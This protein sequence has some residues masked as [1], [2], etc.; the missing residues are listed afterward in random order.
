MYFRN[1]LLHILIAIVFLCFILIIGGCEYHTDK[2]YFQDVSI[3][4]SAGINIVLDPADTV[5][6]LSED[7]GFIYHANS[8]NRKVYNVR[9]FVDTVKVADINDSIGFFKL[10]VDDYIEG[11]HTLTIIA[12]TST[13]SGSLADLLGSEGFVFSHSWDLIV[14]KLAPNA[15][16][17]TNIFN[18]NGVLRIE[19]GIFHK[20]HFQ[21]YDVTKSE[22]DANGYQHVTTIASINQQNI[23]YCYDRSFAGGTASYEVRVVAPYSNSGTSDPR[24]F[25][26]NYI[27]HTQWIA[28]DLVKLDWEKCRYPG[29]FKEYRIYQDN[30]L[31]YSSNNIDSISF[32][33][34][35]GI[36]GE[37]SK[38][39]MVIVGSVDV[40]SG[41]AFPEVRHSIGLPFG[42]YY[43]FCSNNVN[44]NVILNSASGIYRYNADTR[45]M[46]DSVV[47]FPV[48]EY[49]LSPSDNVLVD[50][51]F[52]RSINPDNLSQSQSNG[53]DGFLLGSLSDDGL[54]IVYSNSVRKLYD[55]VNLKDISVFTGGPAFGKFYITPDSKYYFYQDYGPISCYKIHDGQVDVM[56]DLPDCYYSLMPDE[57][58]EIMIFYNNTCEIRIIETNQIVKSFGVDSDFIIGI[59]PTTQTVMFQEI[60]PTGILTIYNYISGIKQKEFRVNTNDPINYFRGSIYLAS[61]FE[62]PINFKK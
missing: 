23:N 4:D 8:E 1:Y 62:I 50:T 12:T 29:A 32:S 19:W 21:R 25:T 56:Y 34:H 48:S 51:Y 17:I 13:G 5:Y 55:F 47:P 60:N 20:D 39:K 11:L 53:I 7:K 15:V 3:P 31:V 49:I 28:E 37:N 44:E 22:F 27:L 43:T 30:Q 10:N 52:S 58:G 2:V 36:V 41:Q 16:Q 26:D 6:Y 38:Y 61:G 9:V 24:G 18:E 35:I 59:D 57:S 33:K 42:K 46:V 40:P 54:G 45:K 14:N